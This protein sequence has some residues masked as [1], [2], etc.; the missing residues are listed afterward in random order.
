MQETTGS[1]KAEW[2]SY[3]QSAETH[4]LE[5]TASVQIGKEDMEGVLHK[6]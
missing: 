4:Y 6:W 2:T 5:D 1:I 3:T